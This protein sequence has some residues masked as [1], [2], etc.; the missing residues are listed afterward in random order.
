MRMIDLFRECLATTL[1][2]VKRIESGE[3]PDFDEV[4]SELERAFS[5]SASESLGSGYSEDQYEVAKF[6]VVAFVDEAF[7]SSGWENRR[8]WR[9]EPLQ[10][11]HFNSMN[12][13]VEFFDNLDG[14]ST[15]NPAER[16]IREVY[17]VVL[18]LGF[19]GRYYGEG[20]QAKLDEIQKLNL[21]LLLGEDADANKLKTR[22]L[23]PDAEPEYMEGGGVRVHRG[24]RALI[25]GV[26]V[27]LLLALFYVFRLEVID[28]ADAL[29]SVL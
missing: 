1:D 13:G 20:D 11:A 2:R 5:N 8:R 4:R 22:A 19:R 10:L 25:Y 23:F 7:M 24:K 16:D 29:V 15:V 27:L 28:A 18:N 26:P 6:A 9:K 21:A 14:L 17:Y 3:N 12:A